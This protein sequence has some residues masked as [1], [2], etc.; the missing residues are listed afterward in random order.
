MNNVT[1]THPTVKSGWRYSCERAELVSHE[2][3]ATYDTPHPDKP[4][5]ARS[6]P[7]WITK[8]LSPNTSSTAT[9]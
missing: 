1:L 2:A 9:F 4:H 6:L 5:S 7:K 8:R 3:A